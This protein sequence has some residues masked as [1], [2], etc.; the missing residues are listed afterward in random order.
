MVLAM[1][2][3]ETFLGLGLSSG[4]F[5]AHWLAGG[6]FI[7]GFQFLAVLVLMSLI[8]FVL[9]GYEMEGPLLAS[10]IV[11]S[12]LI[13]HFLLS[14]TN[15]TS[16]QMM[17][18]HII[19]GFATYLLLIYADELISWFGHRIS[20]FQTSIVISKCEN[21]VPT[22]LSSSGFCNSIKDLTRNWSPAPPLSFVY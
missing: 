4:T 3:R 17:A 11:I 21:F 5:L 9:S 10:A 2:F 12:Q 13:G 14:D 16:N 1:R 8:G 6:T 20:S 7:T 22:S 15:A 18:S 19:I